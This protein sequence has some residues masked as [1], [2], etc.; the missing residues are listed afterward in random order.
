MT[1]VNTF[2][3]KMFLSSLIAIALV[4]ILFSAIS[5]H[6]FAQ[7]TPFSN[8]TPQ[9]SNGDD[10][11]R[12]IYVEGY[13]TGAAENGRGTQ[14]AIPNA[15][16]YFI[17][18]QTIVNQTTS[19]AVGFYSV[20]I[21]PGTYSVVTVAQ[22][23]QTLITEETFQ[24]TVTLDRALN[25][26]PYTGLVVY[27]VNPVIETSPGRPVTVTIAI[28][29]SQ[30]MDQSLVF[31]I[32]APDNDHGN[33]VGWCPDGEML[34]VRSSDKSEITFTLQYNGVNRGAFVWYV[35]AS[36]G[37]FYA[38]IP[39]VVVVKDLPYESLDLYSNY[40][41]RTVNPGSINLFQFNVNNKYSQDKPLAID[42]QKPTGWGVTT[43]NGSY[44]YAAEQQ[45]ADSDLWV[46]VP[47]DTTPGF[48]M[49]NMTL[50]GQ[51]VKSNTLHF[52]IQVQGT[53]AYDALI[54]GYG[55]SD[56]GYPTINLSEGDTFDLPVRVYNNG[57]FPLDLMVSAEIGDNWAYYLDDV[58]WNKIEVEPGS[59][60]EFTVR[61]Q[62]PNGTVGNF[63]AKIYLDGNSQELNGNDQ[64]D[65]LLAE[66]CVL[67]RTDPVL[68]SNTLGGLLLAA[69]T[70]GVILVSLV[71]TARK[72]RRY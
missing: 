20:I 4:F 14:I 22:G 16:I 39:V 17:K 67:P 27:P 13:I 55:V 47:R 68:N 29:N 66:L 34:N 51:D 3:K 31:G 72:R 42:I 10:S 33:W 32:Q 71:T 12:S 70:G 6:A 9:T 52:Q 25:I 45:Q 61:C 19:S 8:S 59:A 36:G 26:V 18:N 69:G 5:P 54:T 65:K 40:P 50:I 56:D 64:E 43:G 35:L 15:A 58:P 57:Q 30:L 7:L 48:Y 37:S 46:Y 23:F 41:T 24:G 60:T 53:P 2:I 28:E 63:T 11:D 38:K 49:V 1:I 62:V 44:F 21:T